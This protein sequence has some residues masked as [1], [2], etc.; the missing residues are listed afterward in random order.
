MSLTIGLLIP[1]SYHYLGGVQQHTLSLGQSLT[2]LGHR[3]VYLSP[4]PNPPT[5]IQPHL[6]IGKPFRIPTPNGS[7]TE[8][9]L[10]LHSPTQIRQLIQQFNLDL[11]HFHELLVPYTTWHWLKYSSVPNLATLHSGWNCHQH[12]NRWTNYYRL[13][14]HFTHS[15]LQATIG[16][17][18]LANL[19]N[20]QLLA[21]QHYTIPPII[22]IDQIQQPLPT[23][24]ALKNKRFRHL[25]F[26]GRL[27]NRK[28]CR[29]LIEAFAL[30]PPTQRQQL[31]IHLI[32][33]GPNRT[34]LKQRIHQLHLQ[35]QIHFHGALKGKQ[36]I[37]Y[38]QHADLYLAPT[39]KGESFGM[40]L[41]E[42]LAAGL[43]LIA[44]NNEAYQATLK[45]YPYPEYILD[46]HQ[47]QLFAQ[48]IS[49]LL[50]NPHHQHQIKTWAKTFVNQFSPKVIAQQHLNIYHQLLS[51]YV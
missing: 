26:L 48:K 6:T 30:I 25:L 40:V 31:Q 12:P 22:E 18:P 43:P 33:D 23:P 8:L 9:S 20:H 27:D 39:T 28:G 51:K 1:Y 42:A 19:C 17:S 47:H 16:V 46:P 13:V 37:A 2:Q 45:D 21:P 49:Q 4:T 5:S 34:K 38:L 7:W 3:V 50:N 11:I 44:G 24:Q 14:H 41:I 15:H 29:H 10:P 36:K 32:G 35:A